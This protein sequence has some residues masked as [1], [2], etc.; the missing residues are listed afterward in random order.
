MCSL[1]TLCGFCF[2]FYT[3]VICSFV[4]NQLL[5]ENVLAKEFLSQLSQFKIETDIVFS[6]RLLCVFLIIKYVYLF[7]QVTYTYSK[8]K[9]IEDLHLKV[10]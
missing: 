3:D 6:L 10:Q 1:E 5:K 8:P 9:M 4:H 7:L 2:Y